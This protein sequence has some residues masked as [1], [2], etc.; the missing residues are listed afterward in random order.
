MNCVIDLYKNRRFGMFPVMVNG[1]IYH[2]PPDPGAEIGALL[3]RS[4]IIEDLH[5][6]FMQN[7]PGLFSVLTIPEANYHHAAVESL[8]QQFLEASVSFDA[9]NDDVV[10]LIF[11]CSHV[12]TILK[13][14]PNG[15]ALLMNP[16]N[17]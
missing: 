5:K 8:I 11:G 4:Q 3:E 6:A 13:T 10:F 2:D 15:I 9:T 17:P 16:V 1:G 7:V 14:H 12:S